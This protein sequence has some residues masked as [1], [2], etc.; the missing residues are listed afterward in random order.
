MKLRQIPALQAYWRVPFIV[1]L[2]IVLAAWI[3]AIYIG[4]LYETHG[5]ELLTN[6]E[7]EQRS[8]KAERNTCTFVGK[9]GS[10]QVSCTELNEHENEK[11]NEFLQSDI[12]EFLLEHHGSILNAAKYS[13]DNYIKE[14]VFLVELGGDVIHLLV[15][16]ASVTFT[17]IC[18]LIAVIVL[19]ISLPIFLKSEDE[20]KAKRAGGIVKTCL[21]FIVASG[22]TLVGGFVISSALL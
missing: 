1:L 6:S 20:Q 14:G 21:G 18:I 13:S 2:I 10:E 9:E 16:I 4:T 3:S 7:V 8:Q 5:G 11:L 17:A 22:T 12:K 15:V 19:F